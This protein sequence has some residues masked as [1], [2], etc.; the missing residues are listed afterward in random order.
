MRVHRSV[1]QGKSERASIKSWKRKRSRPRTFVQKVIRAH[2]RVMYPVSE[3]I[4]QVYIYLCAIVCIYYMMY[5]QKQLVKSP[6]D[7]ERE[8]ERL[9][10]RRVAGRVVGGARRTPGR[11][12]RQREATG[13]RVM[14]L[15]L[16]I[17]KAM[18]AKAKRN[19]CIYMYYIA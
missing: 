15:Y 13:S 2:T 12:P 19:L 9:R 10:T 6:S 17:E 14:V 3:P 11:D 18:H 5:I 1:C 4:L 16:R 7:G 8:R